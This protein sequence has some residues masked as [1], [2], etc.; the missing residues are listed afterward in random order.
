MGQAIDM[1]HQQSLT[2]SSTPYGVLSRPQTIVGAE[3]PDHS[4]HV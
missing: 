1:N 2:P 4:L 3:E